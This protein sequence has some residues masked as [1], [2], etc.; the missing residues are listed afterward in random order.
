MKRAGVVLCVLAPHPPLLIPEIGKGDIRAVKAT[1]EAMKELACR[2]NQAK[3]DVII[4]IS[5]HAPLFRDAIAVLVDD[6]LCGDFS[7]FGVAEA[8]YRFRNDLELISAIADEAGKIGVRIYRFDG[9]GRRISRRSEG[10]D[11][12]VLVPM[13]FISKEI[14]QAVPIVVMGTA[15]LP[16]H[17]L[18]ALGQAIDEAARRLERRAVLVAS[19]DLSHRLTRHAPAGYNPRGRE[20]D[21]RLIQCLRDADVQ[22][23]LSLDDSLLDEAG[24][25]GYRPVVTALGA[26]SGDDLRSDVLSYEGPFGVGYGCALF[27]PE[28][29]SG[30]NCGSGRC[31][32]GESFP[33]KL[34]RAAVETY[35]RSGKKINPPE[36]IPPEFQGR[37]GV[38]CT[39]K[40]GGEL[41]GCIGTIEPATGSIAREII[42]N[43]IAAATQDPRFHPVKENEL[44]SLSYS[45]DVLMPSEPVSGLDQLNPGLY[46]VIVRKGR[47]RGLLLPDIEGVDT[48]L[49]QVAIARRKAGIGPNE[50]IEIERFEVKRHT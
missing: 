27:G 50:D 2:V 10:L 9:E 45:V 31:P 41:R 28:V 20:F 37:A 7:A 44:R 13:H 8:Q 14:G 5:P 24:E 19:G 25:C 46:G 23:I 33:V 16:R 1:Q 29:D 30:E 34:A 49:E 43:A 11:H 12:G 48:P 4:V 21:E 42:G 36:E 3:P 38:F 26:V 18:Y 15:L 22:G 47:K 39:L 40:I 35:V 32:S 17:A 6:P